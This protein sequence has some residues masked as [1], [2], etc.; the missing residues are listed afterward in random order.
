MIALALLAVHV[1]VI[2][3]DAHNLQDLAF[4]VAQG[5]GYFKDEGVE[6]DLAVP[7]APSEARSAAVLSLGEGPARA[8]Q[9][10]VGLR[11]S[12]SRPRFTA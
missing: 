6:L 8:A 9:G 10:P 5:A 1:Q 12:L 4:F 11:H 3:P 2:V 7:D